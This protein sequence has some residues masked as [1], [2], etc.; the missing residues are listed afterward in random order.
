VNIVDRAEF[1]RLTEDEIATYQRQA[2]KTLVGSGYNLFA[3]ITLRLIEHYYAQLAESMNVRSE[4]A[5]RAMEAEILSQENVELRAQLAAS[6]LERKRLQA[7]VEHL[8]QE[9][10]RL[11]RRKLNL[12]PS[13]KS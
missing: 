8:Q 7:Q 13:W 9:V 6:E 4:G 1:R 11:Q 12:P 3:E 10:E 2:R 5:D